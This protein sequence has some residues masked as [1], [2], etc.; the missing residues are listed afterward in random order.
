MWEHNYT[1]LSHN[2]ALSSAV[3]AFPV[4]VLL[5][6]LGVVRKAAW[7]SSLTGLAAAVLVSLFIY[8]MPPSIMLSAIGYGAAH[9][10]ES[11]ARDD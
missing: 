9:L 8:G 11:P 2:L 7:I 1:P 3:A 10:T 6:M 5:L 4:L